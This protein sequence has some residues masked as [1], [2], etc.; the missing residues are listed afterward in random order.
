MNTSR[1]IL[2]FSLLFSIFFTLLST[3]S[4]SHSKPDSYENGLVVTTHALA[5]QVGV[6]ILKQGGNAVDAA[7]AV[8][9][10]LAV[11]YPE[12]G[13]IGGGGFMVIRSNDGLET[14]IDFREKAPGK[15]HQKMYLDPSGNV[16]PNLSTVGALSVGV[17]GSVAGT[18]YALEKYGTMTKEQV[19]APAIELAEQGWILDRSLGGEKFKQFD[20]SNA[21][22][23][24]ADGS[25]YHEGELFVQKD[26]GKTLRFISDKGRDG[27]YKGQIAQLLVRTM[28]KFGG[29][30]TASDLE[31]Y[32]AVERPLVKGSYRGYEVLSMAPP[33]SGGVCLI[34]LL[35][36]IETFDIQSLSWNSPQSVHLI[37]EAEKRAYADRS[38]YLGDPD[39][40]NIPMQ[41]LLS[42]N[43]AHK[44]AQ[45]IN[46]LQATPSR[47]ISHGEVSSPFKESEETT[48]FSIVDKD[49]LCVSMTT[50]LNGS[51][52]SY[53]VA[54]GAGFL[55]NNEMDD[56]VSKP[57][58][59]NMYGLLGGK[60]NA[61]EAN[62]RMLSSMT[63]TIVTK[64]GK[65]FMII[66]SPGGSTIITTVLQCIINVIDHNMSIQKAVE[67]ARFHHQWYPDVIQYE[68]NRKALS[69]PTMT[70]LHALGHQLKARGDIGDA[71]GIIIDPKT[72]KYFGGADP[73]GGLSAAIGY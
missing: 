67:A 11:V 26:L 47:F 3:F 21:V 7:V 2:S 45:E 35:N 48:H 69:P 5:S 24:K 57:G 22:F 54:E 12:A 66:G 61:I 13:N 62:K 15:A 31:N 8:S 25:P 30:I 42:K 63:P 17:P 32:R 16:V 68:E 71:H 59:P 29:W 39:F 72:G 10:A 70:T 43:Y 37:S 65:N 53:L 9:Y 6:D 19:L 58:V 49:G 4:C 33:S 27:F 41:A 55:L 46:P 50:T 51:F 60:A 73:R 28:E 56:F 36:M 23:N 34:E 64:N 18:L 1:K 38:K 44:R 52:G 14:S 20:S 40:V